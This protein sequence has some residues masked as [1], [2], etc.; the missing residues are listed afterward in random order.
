MRAG[1]V[2]FVHGLFSMSSFHSEN[3]VGALEMIS[4]Q[5]QDQLLEAQKKPAAVSPWGLAGMF[6]ARSPDA[7]I[8]SLASEACVYKN[9]P[10]NT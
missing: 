10:T 3:Q 4:R 2:R 8:F 5:L 1:E 6:S 9:I 7:G